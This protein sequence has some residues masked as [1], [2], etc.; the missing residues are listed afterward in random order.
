MKKLILLFI[1]SISG[2]GIY[3]QQKSNAKPAS[4]AGTLSDKNWTIASTEEWGVEKKPTDKNKDD[5]MML[6]AD[7]TFSLKREG[8]SIEGTYKKTGAYIYFT[9]GD[10]A[11]VKFNYK[12]VS[13]ESNVLKVDYR[14]AEGLHTLYTFN[15]K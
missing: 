15:T 2:I 10:A 6:K 3:A 7:G 12:V 13:A 9:P 5:F 11:I 14:E 4:G 8:Q 1:F